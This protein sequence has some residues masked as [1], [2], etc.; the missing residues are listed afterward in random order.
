MC[1]C[2]CR[3]AFPQPGPALTVRSDADMAFGRSCLFA[4]TSSTCPV[5]EYRSAQ[6]H[7]LTREFASVQK[8]QIN[9][10]LPPPCFSH[11]PTAFRSSSSESIRCNSSR[12][13][14]ALPRCKE[15][16]S[17]SGPFISENDFQP[18]S[19]V[20]VNHEDKTLLIR[21]IRRPMELRELR[22]WSSYKAVPEYWRSSAA[23]EVESGPRTH[24]VRSPKIRRN[25]QLMHTLS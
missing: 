1:A 21:R 11:S 17:A 23:K 18:V 20:A 5:Q 15:S 22:K 16:K 2:V 14:L 3:C 8:Q 7:F 19:V 25:Q 4:K 10:I 6:P 13:S 24:T 12:A 9:A